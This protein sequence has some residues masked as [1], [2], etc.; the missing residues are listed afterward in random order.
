MVVGLEVSIE[1]D[2]RGTLRVLV[3]AR[4]GGLRLGATALHDTI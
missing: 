4:R 2:T 3:L 1:R